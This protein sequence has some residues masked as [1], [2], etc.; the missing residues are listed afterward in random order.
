MPGELIT[1][2]DF[3]SAVL[4][5]RRTV[6][7]YLP[8]GYRKD[9]RRHYPVLYLHDGQN[10]F[11]P[12]TSYVPGEHWRMKEAADALL[13]R[14]RIEPLIIAAIYHAGERRLWEYTPSKTRKL[15]GGGAEMHGRMLVGDLIPWMAARFRT[16]PQARHTAVGGSSMG[17]LATLHLGLAYPG[18][19]GKLAVMSPSVW[20]DHRV[21]LRTLEAFQHHRRPRIWLDIGTEEGSTRTGSLRDVRLLKAML[22]GKGWREGRNLHYVEAEGADHSERAWAARAPGMLEFLF[23][24]D[25]D[26]PGR[27]RVPDQVKDRFP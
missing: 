19:F 16:L 13:E 20:W 27:K 17:G 26:W 2:E 8:A 6:V 18:V 11:D 7:V 12:R 5:G 1:I 22:V 3:Q 10:V 15:D 21:I 9:T 23:P 14:R 24:R 4:G 25:T